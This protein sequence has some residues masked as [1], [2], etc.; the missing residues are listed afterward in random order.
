MWLDVTGTGCPDNVLIVVTG[1]T[2]VGIRAYATVCFAFLQFEKQI[3]RIIL[4][5]KNLPNE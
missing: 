2:V 4:G 3:E 5:D 1:T